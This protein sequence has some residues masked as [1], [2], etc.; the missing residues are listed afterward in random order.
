[1]QK[2][3]K[4]ELNTPNEENNAIALILNGE[5]YETDGKFHIIDST[6]V[7]NAEILKLVNIQLIDGKIIPIMEIN[8]LPIYR[9]INCGLKLQP[10]TDYPICICGSEMIKMH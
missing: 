5:T 8:Q 3:F 9:C 4:F 1:M 7:I 6:T 2:T 10:F